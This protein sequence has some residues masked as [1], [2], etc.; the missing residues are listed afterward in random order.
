MD[1]VVLYKQG[2]SHWAQRIG[3]ERVVIPAA[4]MRLVASYDWFMS[5]GHYWF[6]K[7]EKLYGRKSLRIHI[8]RADSAS[9]VMSNR[10]IICRD[11]K[12]A[13]DGSFEHTIN[14]IA[15]EDGHIGILNMWNNDNGVYMPAA[16]YM[17]HFV[18]GDIRV[19][20]KLNVVAG[21]RTAGG[22]YTGLW[23]PIRRRL[24][25]LHNGSSGVTDIISGL[26]ITDDRNVGTVMVRDGVF[27]MWR[28]NSVTR[29]CADTAEVLGVRED[30]TT[31]PPRM[32][33]EHC[34][35]HFEN[36]AEIGGADMIMTDLRTGDRYTVDRREQGIGRIVLIL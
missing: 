5:A 34:T 17:L 12:C 27:E 25:L 22:S 18:D 32:L 23:D 26:H 36:N 3:G 4:S 6:I 28:Y 35:I 30:L 10:T 8:N 16:H 19:G 29:V 24:H 33:G 14:M 1:A 7:A 13:K 20:E 2:D 21:E 11:L 15:R 31:E 9:L